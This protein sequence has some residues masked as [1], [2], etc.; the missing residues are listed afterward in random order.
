M[1]IY[2]R[3]FGSIPYIRQTCKSLFCYVLSFFLLSYCYFH[4]LLLFISNNRVEFSSR[5]SYL[6]FD[7]FV[8]TA[9]QHCWK[10]FIIKK[11]YENALP[12]QIQFFCT[13][14][15]EIFSINLNVVTDRFYNYIIQHYIYNFSN[16]ISFISG[17][18][19]TSRRI[20]YNYFR[21]NIF[22]CRL[23]LKYRGLLL[24]LMKFE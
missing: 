13:F 4:I 20:W 22:L 15:L 19:F 2:N 16:L 21:I 8:K 12:T 23:C 11:F 5:A 14:I 10:I 24:F 7:I 18:F 3:Q 6:G 1:C 17:E 9:L